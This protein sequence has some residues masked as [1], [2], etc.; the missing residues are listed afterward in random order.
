MKG[1][2]VNKKVV[3]SATICLL[4]I[5]VVVIICHKVLQKKK[6]DYGSDVATDDLI[7]F[8]DHSDNV[9]ILQRFLNAKLIVNLGN[10]PEYNGETL[11]SLDVDGKFGSR[12]LCATRWWFKK[13]TVMLSEIQ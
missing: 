8:G 10:R 2:K 9:K 13:D 7:K 6:V 4:I 5:L 1:L 3:L 12:T 11:N